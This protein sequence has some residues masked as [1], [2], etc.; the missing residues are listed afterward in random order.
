M[1]RANN[2]KVTVSVIRYICLAALAEREVNL[3]RNG[4][5]HHHQILVF[6]EL[7]VLSVCP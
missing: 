1:N 5:D 7:L 6:E 2:Q 4:E 3:S